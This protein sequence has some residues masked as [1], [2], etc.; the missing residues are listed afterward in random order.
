[1]F[2]RRG[3]VWYVP[4]SGTASYLDR[5]GILGPHTLLVHGVQIAAEERALLQARQVAWAHC[6]K[7]N[8]KLGNGVA[9]L[10]M[11]GHRAQEGTEEPA[12]IGLGSDSMVSNNTMDLFEEMRFAV[13]MQRGARRRIDVLT[14]R[15]A[16][17]MATWGGARALG[18]EQ[19][20][21]TLEPGKRADLCAVRTEE[22]HSAP[23]YDPYNALVYAARASDVFLTWI[24]GEVVYD[25]RRGAR[26]EDHFPQIDL[27]SIRVQFQAAANTMRH[28]RPSSA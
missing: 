3:I 14:A 24:G 5:L 22:L 8:A 19:E 6:P 28:W 9:P 17:R 2:V 20:I 18:L 15:E 25:T 27:A 23:T 10:D 21:G 16:V 4:K 1:M 12:R 13:L 7:S 26:S 11:L